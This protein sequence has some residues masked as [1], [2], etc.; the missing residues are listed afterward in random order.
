MR[1]RCLDV[2]SDVGELVSIR[3]TFVA[4]K[5]NRRLKFIGNSGAIVGA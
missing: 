4:E 5:L 2:Q 1:T 3:E